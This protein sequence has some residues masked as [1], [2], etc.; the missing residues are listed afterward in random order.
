MIT[1]VN[2]K[3]QGTIPEPLRDRYG[4]APG[5][6]VVWAG[7]RRRPHPQ[8]PPIGR[9]AAWAFQGGRADG[10]A[11]GGARPGPHAR[12]WPIA[13]ADRAGSRPGAH[14]RLRGPL[15]EAAGRCSAG[16]GFGRTVVILCGMTH[17]VGAK[18]Q[19]VI[20]KDLRDRLGIGPG[21]EVEFALDEG[22]DAVRLEPVRDRPTLRGSLAG[23]RLVAELEADHRSE[24]RR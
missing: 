23:L 20:P 10:N 7:V 11:A 12:R 4:F 19:V 16:S 14:R 1:T 6:K 3:G 2:P 24:A 17:R 22:G 8:A 15:A 13:M 21:D 5:T 18:G 9:A